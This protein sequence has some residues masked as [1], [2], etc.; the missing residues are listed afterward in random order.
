MP[1][2]EGEV[3]FTR[4]PDAKMTDPIFLSKYQGNYELAGEKIKLSLNE[5]NILVVVIPEQPVYELVPIKMD[6]FKLKQFSDIVVHFKYEN[7]AIIGFDLSQP[8]G[9]FRYT[10]NKLKKFKSIHPMTSGHWMNKSTFPALNI[11]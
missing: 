3:I 4:K 10:K 5:D 8:S 7:D 9:V 1:V 11:V 6:K 2:D